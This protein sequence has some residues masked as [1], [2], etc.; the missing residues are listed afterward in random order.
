M[1]AVSSSHSHCVALIKKGL[2]NNYKHFPRVLSSLSLVESQLPLIY[3]FLGCFSQPPNNK[4]EEDGND[5]EL[6]SFFFSH[7]KASP[8]TTTLTRQNDK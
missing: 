4:K 1:R 7:L 5:E 8:S 3:V 6:F 2:F